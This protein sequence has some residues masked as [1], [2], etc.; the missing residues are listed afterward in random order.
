MVVVGKRLRQAEDFISARAARFG[1]SPRPFAS[2]DDADLYLPADTIF[3]AARQLEGRHFK[4]AQVLVTAAADTIIPEA[5]LQNLLGQSF[6][7]CSPAPQRARSRFGVSVE[8]VAGQPRINAHA[9]SE[10]YFQPPP[11]LTPLQPP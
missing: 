10:I 4:S 3:S 2:S 5:Q 6:P 11:A 9:P 7:M 8:T 1:F